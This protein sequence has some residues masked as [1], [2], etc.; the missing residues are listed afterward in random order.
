MTKRALK[1]RNFST[2]GQTA[3]YGPNCR[4]GMKK[5]S[6]KHRG[7]K[8][9]FSA[10]KETK[11]STEVKVGHGGLDYCLEMYGSR[12]CIPALNSLV[13]S[14]VWIYSLDLRV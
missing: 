7:E 11:H 12:V 1:Y 6:F 3:T 10:K 14:S 4:L 13:D 5:V 9:K 8:Y 2:Y